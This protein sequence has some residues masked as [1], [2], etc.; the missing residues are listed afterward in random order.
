MCSP[1]T[2]TSSLRPLYLL[3]L[4][5]VLLIPTNRPLTVSTTVPNAFKGRL[6]ISNM[7]WDEK[8]ANQPSPEFIS[9]ATRMEENLKILFSSVGGTQGRQPMIRVNRFT[10][11]R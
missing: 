1:T 6:R 9:L 8:L 5:Q 10:E 7:E 11:G 4:T 3:Q 2:L